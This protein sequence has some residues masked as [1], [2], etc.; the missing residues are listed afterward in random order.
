MAEEETIADP[1]LTPGEAPADPPEPQDTPPRPSMIPVE[2]FN[3]EVLGLRQKNRDAE[4]ALDEHRRQL[5]DA[6]ELL[7]R[8][9]RN[10]SDAATAPSV[11]PT[12]PPLQQPDAG[13]IDRR[14][15]ELLFQ[16]DAAHISETAFK[17]YGQD[18]V[19]SLGLL[20][21]LG[22]NSGD[23][24]GSVMEI[25]G[26]DKTHEVMHA[27]AQDPEK[28]ASLAGMSPARRIAEITRT[29][30]KMTAKPAAAETAP[31]APVAPARTVSRA[32]NPAPPLEPSA[33]KVVDWRS[34]AASDADFDRGFQ[35]MLAKRNA[36]R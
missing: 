3:R 23:F 14:A 25:V 15:S 9:Q 2:T 33:S 4:A 13:D 7:A 29:A 22:L 30:E 18:W 24:V 17:S 35:E 10:P 26:P 27:I 36:R 1:A 21:S 28:A 16:R 5:S 6:R 8:L 12:P 11:Q 32:P 19:N 34:D 20:N 31:K